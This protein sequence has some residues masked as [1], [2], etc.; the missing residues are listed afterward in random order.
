MAPCAPVAVT[1]AIAPDLQAE[2]APNAQLTLVLQAPAS[3]SRAPELPP[4]RA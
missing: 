2:R 1:V 3:I 4:P